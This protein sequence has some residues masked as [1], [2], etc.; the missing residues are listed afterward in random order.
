MDECEEGLKNILLRPKNPIFL[1]LRFVLPGVK[2]YLLDTKFM[3]AE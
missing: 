3:R 2:I 1:G